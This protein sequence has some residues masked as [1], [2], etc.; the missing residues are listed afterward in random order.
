MNLKIKPVTTI[1]ESRQIED[2]ICAAWGGDHS[3]TI[4]DHMTIT[5]AKE[6][7][8]VVLIAT[9]G[10]KPVGFCWGFLSYVVDDGGEKRLK[11]CSHMAGVIPEYRGKRIG[12]QIKWAQRDAVLALGLDHITWTYD[13][14]EPLNGNLNI[15]KLGGVCSTYKRDVYGDG[16]DDLNWGVPTD[17]FLIDWWI[18]STWVKEHKTKAHPAKSRKEWEVMGAIVVNKPKRIENVWHPVEFNPELLGASEHLLVAVPKN[19]QAVKKASETAGRAWRL[20]TQD[21]FEYIFAQGYTAVDLI[22][23]DE[24]SYYLLEKDFKVTNHYE[25]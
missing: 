13:P 9:D 5:V 21:V 8:G 25:D 10:D 22:R 15:H 23:E 6:N 12:E 11:H 1:E 19:Y 4:P 24:L 14:L 3:I 2:I 20:H 7:G 16:R 17:R 18:T